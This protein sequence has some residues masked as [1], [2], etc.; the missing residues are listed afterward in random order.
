[1]SGVKGKS[2]IYIR[3]EKHKEICCKNLN[4]HKGSIPWNKGVKYSETQ[5]KNLHRYPKGHISWSKLHP[6]YMQGSKHWNWKGGKRKG[7]GY[8]FAKNFGHPSADSNGYVL[9]HRLVIEK[10]IGRYLHKWE[11]AHHINKIKDDNRPKNLMAFKSQYAHLRFEK[12]PNNV[13]PLEII[14]DGRRV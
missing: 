2:G 7:R 8:I 5:K 12:N 3:T 13:K 10:Q 14:F 6:E 11:I 9:E 1:M 4:I